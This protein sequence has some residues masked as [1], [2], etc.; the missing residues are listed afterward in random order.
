MI[1][2]LGSYSELP[3]A[4]SLLPK[5]GIDL[6][7]FL[8]A[9]KLVKG[10]ALITIDLPRPLTFAVLSTIADKSHHVPQGIPQKDTDL[11]GEGTLF[12]QPLSEVGESL[13]HIRTGVAVLGKK[14]SYLGLA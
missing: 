12:L 5:F 6:P 2:F 10:L 8:Q 9:G 4:A 1:I 7:A 3:N 14:M 11:L 13:I